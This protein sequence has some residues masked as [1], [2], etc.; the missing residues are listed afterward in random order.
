MDFLGYPRIKTKFAENIGLY[1]MTPELIKSPR[2]SNNMGLFRTYP[3]MQYC[4][5]DCGNFHFKNAS[6]SI[7]N[8]CITP[9]KKGT[10]K[11]KRI[12]TKDMSKFKDHFQMFSCTYTIAL[13]LICKIFKHAVLFK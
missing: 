5:E 11:M 7:N 13:F 10:F 1:D 4:N 2:F 12:Y 8:G 3:S 9:L 6:V